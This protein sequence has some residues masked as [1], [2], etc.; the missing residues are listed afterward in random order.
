[1]ISII[2]PVFNEAQ[3]VENFLKQ[4]RQQKGNYEIIIVDG[5][6]SDDTIRIAHDNAR[7]LVSKKGR[8]TQM[9]AGASVAKGDIFL[10]LH[11]DTKLSLNAL[12]KIEETLKD[13]R[14]I[15]GAFLLRFDSRNILFRLG[16]FFIRLRSV[17]F[18]RF[19]GD[20]GIFIRRTF[21]AELSGFKEIPV[22]ED[23]DFCKRMRK[24]GG[25]LVIL[26]DPVIISARKYLEKGIIKQHLRNQWIKILYKLRVSPERLA[27]ISEK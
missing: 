3:N 25:Q 27:R 17:L 4:L 6:S 12:L 19:Y 1:M 11:A 8:A 16:E 18:N 26:K 10:F 13:G 15:G 7:T 24:L 21:F 14:V 9:N 2:V 23:Y 20:Q 22:M 5:G